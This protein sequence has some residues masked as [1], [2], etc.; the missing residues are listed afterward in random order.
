MIRDEIMGWLDQFP[1]GQRSRAKWQLGDAFDA[2]GNTVQA[3]INGEK[4]PTEDE[5]AKIRAHIGPAKT[6]RRLKP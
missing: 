5:M 4:S 1:R 3:I 2:T 6:K